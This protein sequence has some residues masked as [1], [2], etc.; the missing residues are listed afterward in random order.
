M[1]AANAKSSLHFN[2]QCH[3]LF[4]SSLP[5]NCYIRTLCSF[6][7]KK[8]SREKCNDESKDEYNNFSFISEKNPI[9][10][11]SCQCISYCKGNYF[12]DGSLTIF[13]KDTQTK[14]LWGI[15]PTHC[16]MKE[17]TKPGSKSTKDYATQAWIKVLD[18]YTL[19]VNTF[20]INEDYPLSL[21]RIQCQEND[22]F[23]QKLDSAFPHLENF[24]NCFRNTTLAMIGYEYDNNK[25]L[26]LVGT[27]YSRHD[28]K[29]MKTK[30]LLEFE[31]RIN[32]EKK[33]SGSSLII[34]NDK[35]DYAKMIGVYIGNSVANHVQQPY[36][37][38]FNQNII[39]WI[40]ETKKC[41]NLLQ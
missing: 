34:Q 31:Y 11:H 35:D 10:H 5:D 25:N 33:V 4:L 41:F 21:F 24:D 38:T 36:A 13:D 26:Y 1:N 32:M 29:V 20:F 30:S 28:Y 6:D 15:G 9:F 37:V 14:T 12:I 27:E 23:Y 8:Q 39:K 22:S 17:S 16:V 3:E 7:F 19:P 18:D 2:E 40:D